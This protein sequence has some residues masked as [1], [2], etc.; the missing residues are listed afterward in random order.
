MSRPWSKGGTEL[1]K[2][3]FGDDRGIGRSCDVPRWPHKGPLIS[4]EGVVYPLHDPACAERGRV[5]AC[6]SMPGG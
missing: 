4:G 3:E 2:V 6:E 5:L 1:V